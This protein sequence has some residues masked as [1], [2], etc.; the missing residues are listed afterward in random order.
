MATEQQKQHLAKLFEI[1]TQ[2]VLDAKTSKQ[3]LIT[4]ILEPTSAEQRL[5]SLRRILL[6]SQL[7]KVQ[8]TQDPNVSISSMTSKITELSTQQLNELAD[9]MKKTF[10]P[11]IEQKK[12]MDDIGEIVRSKTLNAEQK[13]AQI[14]DLLI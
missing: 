2:I 1:Q 14:S 4:V 11:A 5:A 6:E 12:L 8:T 3:K 13:I 7:E 10:D 9:T